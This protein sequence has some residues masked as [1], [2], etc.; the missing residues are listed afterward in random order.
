MEKIKRGVACGL[1][2][3]GMTLA[4]A[5]TWYVDD[6]KYGASGTGKSL[7][8]AF[9]T[10]Q[11]AVTAASAGDT[12]LVAP[13][14]Y[15]RGSSKASGDSTSSRVVINKNITV[16]S[17]EGADKTVIVGAPDFTNEPL[18]GL[19]ENAIRCVAMSATGSVL[20]GFT[21]TGG[22]VYQS[23]GS[24]GH[25]VRGG[26]VC[27]AL[28]SNNDMHKPTVVDCVISNNVATRGGGAF[29]GTLVRCF[30]AE[31]RVYNTAASNKTRNGAGARSG[32]YYNC[33][34]TRNDDPNSQCGSTVSWIIAMANCTVIGNHSNPSVATD[35]SSSSPACV[36]NSIIHH[37]AGNLSASMAQANS[38][39]SGT[40]YLVVSPITD[41]WRPIA[42]SAADGEGN[43]EG[44]ATIPEAYRDKDFYGNP[45]TTDGTVCVGAV[46]GVVTPTGG[47]ITFGNTATTLNGHPV[48]RPG[49]YHHA[50]EWP[51]Q[52]YLKPVATNDMYGFFGHVVE[53]KVG[54]A[55][56]VWYTLFNDRD[57]GRWMTLPE[58]GTTN[59]LTPVFARLLRVDAA[60]TAATPDGSAA[61][62]YPTIQEAVDA[63]VTGD[64]STY[65][66]I[67]VA[68]G[69]YATGESEN[70]WGKAR[71]IVPA[72]H[73]LL[74]SE[75]GPENTVIVGAPDPDADNADGLG[76]NALRCIMVEGPT[77]H[78]GISGFTLTGGRSQANASSGSDPIGHGGAFRFQ[79]RTR[80]QVLDCIITNNIA[81][82]GPAG[83][84][85]WCQRCLMAGNK[86]YSGG[87]AIF[88]E[89]LLSSCV[90]RDN[91]NAN[92]TGIGQNVRAYG[93]T[94]LGIAGKGNVYTASKGFTTLASNCLFLDGNIGS[95]GT[96]T[97]F[98]WEGNYADTTGSKNRD[99][100]ITY[101]AACVVDKDARDFRPLATSPLVGGGGTSI[102]NWAHYTVSDFQNRPI[103]F[104]DGK[105][106]IGAYQHTVG[107]VVVT[108]PEGG[109]MNAVTNALEAGETLTGTITSTERN[110]LGISVNGEYQEGV[111]TWT[112]TGAEDAPPTAVN[113]VYTPDWYV[114]AV[115][116]N[117]ANNGWTAATAKKTLST[118]AELAV[119]G[120][121]IHALPGVY[122]EGET[123]SPE[124]F[125]TSETLRIKS[126][127]VVPRGVTLVAEGSRED[128]VIEGAAATLTRAQGSNK[129]QMGTFDECLENHGVGSNATRCVTLLA[130]SR[131]KGF[132]LRGGRTDILNSDTADNHIGGAVLGMDYRTCFVE[133]C[134]VE[135]NRSARAALARV[136][137]D[138][139]VIRD[140]YCMWN[141]S[142]ATFSLLRNCL[143]IGNHGERVA[144]YCYGFYNC[145][146]HNNY[147]YKTAS[148]GVY[149]LTEA[150]EADV[151][152]PFV[153]CI[154]TQTSNQNKFGDIR[155]SIFLEGVTV[156]GTNSCENLMRV[157][158]ADDL[159]DANGMPLKGSLAV[160]NGNLE[161]YDAGAGDKDVRG[162]QRVYNGA[163]DVGAFE[164]DWRPDYTAQVTDSRRLSVTAATPEVVSAESGVYLP[165][166]ELTVTATDSRAAGGTQC[167]LT[168]RVTGTGTLAVRVGD[169]TLRELTAADGESAL[170]FDTTGL[171]TDIVCAYT[172]GE[173]ETGG[174]YLSNVAVIDNMIIIFR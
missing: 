137:A 38:I 142:G 135:D 25:T 55:A 39:V 108:I 28:G 174:A 41:D 139:C 149:I 90:F 62:P 5:N 162:G 100:G 37:N 99:V 118:T 82:R 32:R 76:P 51:A 141:R 72:K 107:A 53:E 103:V 157:A 160:D 16:K 35:F 52:V 63:T 113:A 80:Q 114:D 42:G 19:G 170:K 33:V 129:P 79:E 120:D 9:G 30:V 133:D 68:S 26:G 59:N 169:R 123:L 164:Y 15:S 11:E 86:D 109:A 158:S 116:G 43:L 54:S 98:K 27:V 36:W 138:R 83:M 121:T 13:G 125:Y 58:A 44:L 119:S 61:A 151:S 97:N 168:A 88:R 117:D 136:T 23:T 128:T 18:H 127:V 124:R 140:N 87:N 84:Y 73:V 7:Q 85:G 67:R 57:G 154:C 48:A 105:P 49:I 50:A 102:E 12:V 101:G 106:T 115:N 8:T 130:G 6:A 146:F 143:F 172:P 145:T 20:E 171:S 4:A 14:T 2:L 74:T 56:S 144:D 69:T 134:L 94:F 78:V 31:N 24:D 17:I 152:V 155:N 173:N 22:Y 91:L 161:W 93:C 10:I 147:G 122:N 1:A 153:N 46:E 89:G 34:F 3:A 126:R 47:M 159:L 131:I 167:E 64:N 110:L 132:T 66:V 75:Q 21:L 104:S 165:G 111:F 65:R 112:A 92:H 166:G 163:I 71:V 156:Q 70:S 29:G 40:H 45:R 81:Y 60:S 148:T 96:N 150:A 77:A 95:D